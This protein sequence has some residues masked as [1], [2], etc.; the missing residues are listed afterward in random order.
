MRTRLRSSNLRS[1]K[2]YEEEIN[3]LDGVVNIVDAMLVFACG[4][5]LSLVIYWNVDLEESRLVQIEKG[6]DVTQIE[7]I[8]DSIEE[9]EGGKNSYERL[10]SVYKDPKTGKLYML[11]E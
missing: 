7:E 11:E 8:Q 5:M 9:S 4:L 3:P 1:K 10:G 2:T 6:S